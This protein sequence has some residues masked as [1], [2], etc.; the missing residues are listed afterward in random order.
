[1]SSISKKD[2]ELWLRANK[3]TKRL[4]NQEII[5]PDLTKCSYA[6]KLTIPALKN[7]KTAI[8]NEIK[9]GSTKLKKSMKTGRFSYEAVI[10]L[11][12]MT[13]EAAH[14]K[15]IGFIT[16]CYYNRIRHVMII[17]GHGKGYRSIKQE[18]CFWLMDSCIKD[19]IVSVSEAHFRQGGSGAYYILIKRKSNV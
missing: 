18:F 14:K 1:M 4:K 19:Y 9:Y 2:R 6:T 17:T 13:L 5:K 8:K 12:D 7:R 10:D 16:D 3:E 15:V 11:H